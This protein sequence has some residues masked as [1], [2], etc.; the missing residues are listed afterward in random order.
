MVEYYILGGIGAI[1]AG[2]VAH[3]AVKAIWR[4]G[5]RAKVK[6][7]VG[8]SKVRKILKSHA[9][10][11]GRARNDILIPSSRGTTQIDHLL[12]TRHGIFIGETKN[13]SGIV[14]GTEN[15]STWRQFFPDGYTPPRSFLNPIIQN[16]GHIQAIRALLPEYKDVPIHSLVIFPDSTQFPVVPGVFSM[17]ELKNAIRFL[18]SGP[19]VLSQNDVD[20][21]TK[22]ID[23]NRITSR[24]ARSKHNLKASLSAS[25]ND[26]KAI[27]ELIE[28]SAMNSFQIE[29][30]PMPPP[31]PSVDEL[32]EK[33]LLTDIRATLTI[34]GRS[35]TIDGFFE[36]S[37][38][39]DD[40]QTVPPG[41]NF[42]YFICPYTGDKFPPSEALNMYRGLWISYL[43]NNPDL[44]AYMKDHGAEGLGN[45]FKCKKALS[46]YNEDKNGFVSEVRRSE[47]YQNMAQKL[48][49]KPALN[50]QIKA[51]EAKVSAAPASHSH[52]FA[53]ES[54]R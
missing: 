9:R 33:S 47:W 13:Y 46:L 18:S 22:A 29:M 54:E 21:I 38:R 1:I 34:R 4:R 48:S 50:K 20:R 10:Q 15:S 45:S 8:E 39:R 31:P 40:G 28:L 19:P 42:D 35:N 37:K 30:P 43:N 53:K 52:N 3:G 6:G 2:S 14:Q 25:G 26:P 24:K 11:G 16:K 51:A 17:S 32:S 36:G 7:H 44:V 12:V 41:G 23:K 27:N 5:F 49:R